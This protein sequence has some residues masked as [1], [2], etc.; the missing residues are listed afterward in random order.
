MLK[1]HPE[2]RGKTFI[3]DPNGSG[4]Y[5]ISIEGDKIRI[6]KARFANDQITIQAESSNSI[7]LY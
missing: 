5:D 3:A 7:I 2:T 4:Y 1:I 6:R